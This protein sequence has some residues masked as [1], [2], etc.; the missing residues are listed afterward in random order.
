MGVDF[1]DMAVS[2]TPPTAHQEPYPLLLGNY[3]HNDMRLL[4]ATASG[5]QDSGA[6]ATMMEMHDDP[7]AG[8]TAAYSW[9]PGFATEGVYYNR[10]AA[11]DVDG[12]V[13]WAKP[14]SWRH[15]VWATLTARGLSRTVNPV[16]GRLR[17]RHLGGSGSAAV[18]SV[19]VPAAGIMIYCLATVP[20]PGSGGIWPSNSVSMG[21][22]AGGDWRHLVATPKSGKDFFADDTGNH[23]MVIG[24]EYTGAGS[25]GVATVPV[26]KGSP[27]F[28]GLWCFVR[29]AQDV[30]I[31]VGAA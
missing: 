22:P 15:F 12:S 16:G 14:N 31:N 24:R 20:D 9:Q 10:L 30:T 27:A 3:K 1:F 11:G 2:L 19:T 25:T 6:T 26:G 4:L 21:V 17:V 5:I 28:A 23:I 13:T 18:D 8:F 7:P 29:A